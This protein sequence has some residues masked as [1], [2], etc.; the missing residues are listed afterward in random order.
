MQ[1]GEIFMAEPVSLSLKNFSGAAK[2]SVDKALAAH[3]K[4]FPRP[5][6]TIG[7]IPPWWLGIIL[8][9]A[10]Q[11]VSVAEAQALATDIQRGMSGPAAEL[12]GASTATPGCVCVGGHIICGFIR[13]PAVASVMKE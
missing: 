12:H 13:D 11:Q 4:A 6:Y 1:M 7:F 8:I 5:N 3:V 2:A 10:E 9:N